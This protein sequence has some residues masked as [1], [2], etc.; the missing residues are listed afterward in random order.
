LV[1]A[2]RNER[3]NVVSLPGASAP[4]AAL[5]ASGLLTDSWTFRG[6]LPSKASARTT[7]LANNASADATVI[8]F[9]SPNR[10]VKSLEGMKDLFGPDR[11]VCVARELTKMHEE[12]VTGPVSEILQ[13]YLSKTV[14]GEIIILV[15]ASHDTVEQNPDQL[16]IDLLARMPVSKAA[17]EAAQLTGL[18]KRELYQRALKL[19]DVG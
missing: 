17:A 16:L 8:Y 5:V 2:C 4:I 1:E 12:I 9:E 6:F 19:K 10:L 13:H 11:V 7:M 15:S 18:S 3:L 14:K